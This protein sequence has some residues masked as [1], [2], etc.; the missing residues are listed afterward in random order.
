MKKWSGDKTFRVHSW[1]WA[2]DTGDNTPNAITVPPVNF[3][4]DA[5]AYAGEFYRRELPA[6]P[7][8]QP[9]VAGVVGVDEEINGLFNFKL[10]TMSFNF[11]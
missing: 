2:L 6:V 9:A 5:A 4:P 1:Q 7:H 11:A 10:Y 3:L 8:Q